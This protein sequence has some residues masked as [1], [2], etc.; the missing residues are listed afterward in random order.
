M[1]LG[2]VPPWSFPSLFSLFAHDADIAKYEGKVI[3]HRCLCPGVP[4]PPFLMPLT[5]R[6]LLAPGLGPGLAACK[7]S[8]GWTRPPTGSSPARPVTLGAP[9]PWNRGC[10]VGDRCW[11]EPGLKEPVAG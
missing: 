11:P 7:E 9:P 10:P 1:R 8:A 3:G 5:L 4:S 6:V 2:T